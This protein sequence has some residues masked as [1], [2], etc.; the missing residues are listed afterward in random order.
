L[1]HSIVVE[2]PNGEMIVFDGRLDEVS[3][4]PRWHVCL[5][6]EH[7]KAACRSERNRG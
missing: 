3:R 1:Q 2:Y 5:A 4:K 6:V 7:E